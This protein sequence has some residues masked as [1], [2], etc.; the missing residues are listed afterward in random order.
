[1]QT[2]WI[3]RISLGSQILS[4]CFIEAMR[5]EGGCVFYSTRCPADALVCAVISFRDLQMSQWD[6]ILDILKMGVIFYFK[7]N[8]ITI[9][10][11]CLI[12]ELVSASSLPFIKVCFSSNSVG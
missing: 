2:N 8:L 10:V 3:R 6:T 4:L 9:Y 5:M 1:M 12:Y 11:L 7:T